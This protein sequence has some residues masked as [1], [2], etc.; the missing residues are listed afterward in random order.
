MNTKL[1][2]FLTLLGFCF[3][4]F[5]HNNK[6]LNYLLKNNSYTL[7]DSFG[8]D[9]TDVEDAIFLID[10][11]LKKHPLDE[12]ANLTNYLRDLYDGTFGGNW[13]C[14]AGRVKNGDCSGWHD[15]RFI[16]LTSQAG[17]IFLCSQ[18][19]NSRICLDFGAPT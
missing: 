12:T 6:N 3:A 13:N 17:G 18:S 16:N 10:T 5:F 2:L 15:M 9:E 11:A 14:F 4:N 8:F 1:I 7:G 19:C